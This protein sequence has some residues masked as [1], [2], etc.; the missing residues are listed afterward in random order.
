MGLVDKMTETSIFVAFCQL[1][2]LQKLHKK[3][4]FIALNKMWENLKGVCGGN[5]CNL[6]MILRMTNVHQFSSKHSV[7]TWIMHSIGKIWK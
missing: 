7:K 3:S 6:V 2:K 5:L 4:Y 1:R